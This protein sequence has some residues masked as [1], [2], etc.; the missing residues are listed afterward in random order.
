MNRGHK[1]LRSI[2]ALLVVCALPT[3]A[4]AQIPNF[5]SLYVFGDS[6]ADQGNIYRLTKALQHDPAAPPSD[7]PHRTYF[8]GRFS[9]G[10]MGFEYLWQSLSGH[11][12]GSPQGLRPFLASPFGEMSR[13]INFAFGGTGTE[14]VDQTPGGFWAPGLKGQVELF[15]LMRRTRQ[16]SRNALYAITTG[17]N[18]YRIDPYNVPMDPNEVVANIAEAIDTLYQLGARNVM[19]LDLPDLGLL[20]G[21]GGDRASASW[22]SAVHN[23][24]LDAELNELQTRR[25]DLHLIRV[26]LAPLFQKAMSRLEP[27][28]P[29]LAGL[30]YAGAE[31]CLFIGPSL[32]PDV[33]PELFN[34]KLGYVFWDVVHPTTEAHHML[35]EYLYEQLENSYDD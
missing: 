31:L 18:D 14:N 30:G 27:S 24:L 6:L 13:G 23:L 5:D 21:H 1:I 2:A 29:A 22:I 25:P 10:Y 19:V 26:Q 33:S 8:D 15:R 11:A 16:P 32:C 17:A 9:N 20:P 12:P 35:G 28:I 3:A 34:V 4:A 7:S